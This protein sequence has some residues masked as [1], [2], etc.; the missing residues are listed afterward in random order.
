VAR[1]ASSP[2]R[3][4]GSAVRGEPDARVPRPI[5]SS[6]TPNRHP[7]GTQHA[8]VDR[9]VDAVLRLPSDAALVKHIAELGAALDIAGPAEFAAIIDNDRP[10]LEKIVAEDYLNAAN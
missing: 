5:Q 1:S 4:D 9:S 2:Q 7:F 8:F 10:R 6:L 3:G